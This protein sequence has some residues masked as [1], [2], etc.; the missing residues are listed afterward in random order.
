MSG[1]V[2]YSE[3]CGNPHAH[4]LPL[5]NIQLGAL[6]LLSLRRQWI[7]CAA[8]YWPGD[9]LGG[10]LY[11]RRGSARVTG[12]WSSWPLTGSS[13]CETGPRGSNTPWVCMSLEVSLCEISLIGCLCLVRLWHIKGCGRKTS[14]KGRDL[15]FKGCVIWLSHL[16]LTPLK[17]I[18][19]FTRLLWEKAA[20]ERYCTK[21]KGQHI[22]HGDVTTATLHQPEWQRSEVWTF[23]SLRSPSS[24]WPEQWTW[25]PSCP[26]SGTRRGRT[27]CGWCW[28]EGF[29]NYW[30]FSLVMFLLSLGLWWPQSTCLAALCTSWSGDDFRAVSRSFEWLW[31]K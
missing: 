11:R 14:K 8:R 28:P 6:T 4:C 29:Y 10:G 27:R 31:Y 7:E 16:R 30:L 17:G 26:R 18:G 23:Q 5:I 9:V 21:C 15:R 12:P 22:L 13:E 19:A 1:R 24:R 20:I 25:R 3:I 2:V